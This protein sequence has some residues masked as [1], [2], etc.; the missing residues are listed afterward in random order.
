MQGK[1]ESVGSS[2]G[3]PSSVLQW[4]CFVVQL[5][6]VQAEPTSDLPHNQS[7]LDSPAVRQKGMRRTDA[8]SDAGAENPTAT[9]AASLTSEPDWKGWRRW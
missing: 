5:A 6:A 9:I 2:A 4:C 7:N 1:R 3:L 8:K